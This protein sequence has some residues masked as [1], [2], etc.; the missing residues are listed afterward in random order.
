MVTRAITMGID[1]SSASGDFMQRFSNKSILE[2]GGLPS[3]DS[4]AY[5]RI[6]GELLAHSKYVDR[7]LFTF[8]HD[9]AKRFNSNILR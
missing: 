2:T 6:L 8:E 7:L 3:R 9:R 1:F 4:D 5:F